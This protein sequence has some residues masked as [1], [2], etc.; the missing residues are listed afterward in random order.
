MILLYEILI[1][2]LTL[3]MISAIGIIL[4][5]NKMEVFTPATENSGIEQANKVRGDDY[6][7]CAYSY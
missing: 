7:G 3:M 2:Y 4:F 6:Q 1:V 5:V